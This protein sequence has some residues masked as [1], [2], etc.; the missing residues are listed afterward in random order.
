M[1]SDLPDSAA[2]AI[3]GMDRPLKVRG[4]A[5]GLT[6]SEGVNVVVLTENV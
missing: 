6:G 3:L 5:K 4:L 2:R 1:V